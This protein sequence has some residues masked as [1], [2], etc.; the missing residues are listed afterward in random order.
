MDFWIAVVAAG[1]GYI[2][3][4]LHIPS[5]DAESSS[6]LLSRDSNFVTPESPQMRH[7]HGKGCPFRK[8]AQRSKLGEDVS[9]EKEQVTK[10][11]STAEVASTSGFGGE[12][13]V[14][15]DNCEDCRA[16][17]ISNLPPRFLRNGDLQGDKEGAGVSGDMGENSGDSLFEHYTGE[18]SC[19]YG[20]ARK[21]SS[22]RSIR[23]T[24]QY[25]RPLSSLE[26][27]LMAQLYK[28]HTEMEEYVLTYVP[29]PS[30]PSVRPFFVTDGRRTINRSTGNCLSAWNGAGENK[31]HNKT[32]SAENETVFGVPPLPNVGSVELPRKIEVKARKGQ[33]R[34]LSTSSETD[35][36]RHFLSQPGSFH[37]ALIFCLGISVGIISSFIGNKREMD[38]LN[39]LLKQTENLVQDLQEELEIKDS[40]TVK[41]LAIE[42]YESADTHDD[43]YNSSAQ[44]AFILEQNLDESTKKYDGKESHDQKAEEHSESMS[45]IEAELE[46]E[47]ERLEL[48][49]NS[50]S[51]EG[52]LAD[53]PELDGNFIPDIV[54]GELKADIFDRQANAQP[55][56]DQDGS[57]TSTTH[58]ANYA[59][60]PRELSLRLHEVIQSRLEERVKELETALLDS[61]RKVKFLE[62]ECMNSRWG[63]SNGEM[64]SS[65]IQGSPNA[66]EQQ[67]LAGEPVVINLSGEALD[68][69]NNAYDEFM[70]INE[71]EEDDLPSA[72]DKNNHQEDSDPFERN[73]QWDLNGEASHYTP[74]HMMTNGY[75]GREARTLLEH[76]SSDDICAFG[77]DDNVYDEM[78]E[79]L[80]KKI[81]EKARKG[82]PVVLNAQRVLFSVDENEHLR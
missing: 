47:L 13:L 75:E 68:A 39:E 42:D 76:I 38:K 66:T 33:S 67:N 17:P 73:L 49:I 74:H 78:E 41:E 45:K 23:S 25:I 36:G 40:L 59:V 30:T 5:R 15:L 62:S 71:S 44:R 63:F 32:S 12:K 82:S 61:Q 58:S 34:K 43:Y 53:L 56:A 79:L 70:N 21:R 10:G 65:S 69:Y 22:L 35:N 27:C 50:S 20:S 55:Y 80:I 26:S 2:A 31:L 37:G 51:L 52:R 81:V 46:A 72:G 48:T 54:R 3:N 11:A 77:D 7:L 9:L 57:S 1:A 60:S 29:S 28:E 24:M 16:L 64:G 18:M 19:P 6:E 14:N 4:R 8:L